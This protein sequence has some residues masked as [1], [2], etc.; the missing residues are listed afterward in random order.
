M[1]TKGGFLFIPKKSNITKKKLT[2]HEIQ[3]T[4]LHQ[5]KPQTPVEPLLTI[6][7]PKLSNS[8]KGL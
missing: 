5:L 1:N 4:I 8:N 6:N 7:M 2:I 3:Q